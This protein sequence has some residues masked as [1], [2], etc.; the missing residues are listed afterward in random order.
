VTFIC[1]HCCTLRTRIS[2]NRHATSHSTELLNEINEAARDK[3]ADAVKGAKAYEH[4]SLAKYVDFFK[5]EF[6]TPLMT[7]C[8]AARRDKAQEENKLDF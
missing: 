4:T 1:V 5:K 8:A 7:A 3:G 6:V 2:H